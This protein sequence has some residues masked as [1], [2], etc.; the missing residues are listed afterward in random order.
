MGSL[1]HV[2]ETPTRQFRSIRLNEYLL[3]LLRMII[4]SLLVLYL[5]GWYLRNLSDTSRWLVVEPGLEQRSD[6][7][8]LFDSLQ[9]SG[10]EKRLLLPDFPESES[11]RQGKPDYAARLEELSHLPVEEAVVVA[12]NRLAGFPG[13]R[14]SLPENVKWI[15]V[16]GQKGRTEV[17]RV[18]IST[19]SVLVKTGSFEPGATAFSTERISGT[20]GRARDTVSLVVAFDPEFETDKEAVMAVL[21]AIREELPDVLTVATVP[22]A[23]FSSPA[24]DWLIWLSETAAPVSVERVIYV[25]ADRHPSTA[26][27]MTI[28]QAE[29]SRSLTGRDSAGGHPSTALPPSLPL[30]ER[31]GNNQYGFTQRLNSEVVINNN[32]AV[33]LMDLLCH[34]SREQALADSLDARTLPMQTALRP[35]QGKPEANQQASLVEVG[36]EKSTRYLLIVLLVFIVLERLVAYR[37]NQ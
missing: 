35:A 34:D 19:D 29:R 23:R 20:S 17:S 9:A 28:D 31:I 5:S 18:Q 36:N 24:V 26:L 22:V 32:L 8:P 13:P 11:K 2:R 16:D 15:D 4:L 12:T 10:Y 33:H 21:R 14:V 25:D 3:L 37:R 1:R 30:L 6:L 7:Q 27:R